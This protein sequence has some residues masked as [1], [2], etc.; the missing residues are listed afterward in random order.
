MNNTKSK[1]NFLNT[2]PKLGMESEDEEREG[3]LMGNERNTENI[4]REIFKKNAIGFPVTIYEQKTDNRIVEKLLKNAS[5][6]GGGKGKPEFIV[7]FDEIKELLIV[8]L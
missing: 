7:T 8:V 5:K 1:D 3:I 2:T 4:V 6:S